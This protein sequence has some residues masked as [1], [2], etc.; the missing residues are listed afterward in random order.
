MVIVA[1]AAASA[2]PHMDLQNSVE[3]SVVRANEFPA[4]KHTSGLKTGVDGFAAVD[5]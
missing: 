2:E 4:V 3:H 1:R 5:V